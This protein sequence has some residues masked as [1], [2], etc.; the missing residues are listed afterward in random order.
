MP[1]DVLDQQ[2]KV[3]EADELVFIH[4]LYEAESNTE[5]RKRYLELA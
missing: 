1:S 4:F 2:E 5:A 3:T